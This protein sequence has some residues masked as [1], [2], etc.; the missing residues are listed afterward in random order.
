MTAMAVL[1]EA[2]GAAQQ[3]QDKADAVTYVGKWVTV[4]G[5]ESRPELNGAYAFVE[6]GPKE[7]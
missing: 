2:K 7:V 5:L 3:A 6:S 4:A 1:E